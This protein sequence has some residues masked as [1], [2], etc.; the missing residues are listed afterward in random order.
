[1]QIMIESNL[2]TELW[3]QMGYIV[4]YFLQCCQIPDS[5]YNCSFFIIISMPAPFFSFFFISDF[6]L[7][8]LFTIQ[9]L[10]PFLVSPPPS[11]S[12]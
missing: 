2:V 7:F 9:M 11:P 3:T 12:P 1:M 10:Y 8:A 6:S 4:E 5:F